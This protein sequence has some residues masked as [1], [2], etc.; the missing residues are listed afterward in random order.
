MQILYNVEAKSAPRVGRARRRLVGRGSARAAAR[1]DESKHHLVAATPR[2]P[3]VASRATA[4]AAAVVPRTRNYGA[5]ASPTKQGAAGAESG[6]SPYQVTRV[7]FITK[8]LYAP[9]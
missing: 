3:L 2:C 5:P 4:R 1:D 9:N 8:V 6:A 7:A